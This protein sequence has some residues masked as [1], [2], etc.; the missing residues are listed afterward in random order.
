MLIKINKKKKEIEKKKYEVLKNNIIQILNN[1]KFKN[2]IVIFLLN[3]FNFSL[4][5]SFDIDTF[6]V[7]NESI[8]TFKK[9]IMEMDE[10]TINF[11]NIKIAKQKEEF[12][13]S[14]IANIIDYKY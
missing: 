14:I 5:S 9:K 4:E 3:K 11:E 6:K 12:A 1:A 10:D 2:H 8:E 13:D 7:A